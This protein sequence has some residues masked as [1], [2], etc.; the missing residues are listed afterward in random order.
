[1]ARKPIN[2]KGYKMRPFPMEVGVLLH[3]SAC[4]HRGVLY[5]LYII[6]LVLGVYF[7]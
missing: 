4:F 6:C 2:E 3:I 1:M 7:V 5:C